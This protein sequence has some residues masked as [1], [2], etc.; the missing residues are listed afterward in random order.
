MSQIK[1]GILLSY[2]SLILRF[3]VGFFL[4]PFILAHLGPSEYGVY[5][6]AGVIIGWLALCDFGLSASTTKFLSEYQAR[7]DAEGEA[8]HMG[9]ILCIFSIMGAF[10]L[11]AG[12]CIF[13]F[14]SDIFPKFNAEEIR[15]C[16]ILY[17]LTLF[18]AVVMFPG[19]ALG[20]VAASRQKFRTPG[21][22]GL[23]LSIL[24]TIGVVVLLINGV[25]SVG[26]TIFAVSTGVAGLV[27]NIYYCFA[28]LKARMSWSGWDGPLCRSLFAFS[29]WMFLDKVI[30][31]MNT[32]S[33]TFIIGM[34][35]GA[36]EITVYSYGMHLFQHFYSASGC[37]AGFFLPRVVGL[38]VHG[39]S[40][41]EQTDMMIR[42]GRA[43]L[44]VLACLFFGIICFGREFFHLWIGDTLGNRTDDCWFV[45]VVILIPYGFLLLQALGWQLQQARNVMKD[46]V[47][48]LFWSSLF[49]LVVGYVLSI[50]WGCR[51]LAIGTSISVILGQG[52]YMNWY[53]WRRMK[54]EIYRFFK[55]TL[56]RAW[57]WTPLL[58]V[59]AWG[60]NHWVPADNWLTF[61]SKIGVFTAFYALIIFCLYA[62]KTERQMFLSFIHKKS[63]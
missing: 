16:R 6:V 45:S 25:R 20:G 1:S 17:L 56:Q 15:I 40:N 39:A 26:L 10:V 9:M 52:L 59:F 22:V 2:I 4:S 55:E 34:T 35:Q 47:V 61:F 44:I 8:H 49:A 7:G 18:N 58:L 24:N 11:V 3:G 33:G 36:E 62:N 23:I 54:L 57:L 32:G 37:I 42:V 14:L 21:L 41:A 31:I 60:L 19:R 38:V 27:W 13:P 51:G 29:I 5:T 46:R 30:S 50:Y 43:Q 12:I 53:Y 28:V 48:V 63:S